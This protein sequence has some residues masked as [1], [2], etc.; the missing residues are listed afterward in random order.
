MIIRP[1]II[2][3]ME[4]ADAV[5]G[6]D[7]MFYVVSKDLGI[8]VGDLIHYNLVAGGTYLMHNVNDMIYIVTYVEELLDGSGVVINIKPALRWRTYVYDAVSS[9]WRSGCTC[10]MRFSGYY[11]EEQSVIKNYEGNSIYLNDNKGNLIQRFIDDI[12]EINE[13]KEGN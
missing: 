3:S 7:K 9:A 8:K 13:L 5:A 6:G 10:C 11:N 2:T 1:L 4:K 12:V